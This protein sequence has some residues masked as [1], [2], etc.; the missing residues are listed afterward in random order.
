MNLLPLGGIRPRKPGINRRSHTVKL[1]QLL[2][3][4]VADHAHIG[5]LWSG[6][7]RMGARIRAARMISDRLHSRNRCELVHFCGPRLHAIVE[8]W[9]CG[10]VAVELRSSEGDRL[11]PLNCS[12]VTGATTV[13]ATLAG[14]T[15]DCNGSSAAI[16][17][18]W[19]ST[20]SR[21][22]SISAGRQV[23]RAPCGNRSRLARCA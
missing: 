21:S 17:C 16:S 3:D 9:P 20:P 4:D 12:L 15:T 11:W 14:Y 7:R 18:L 19:T 10:R 8:K 22:A 2:K 23:R 13:R 5:E 6:A 1:V